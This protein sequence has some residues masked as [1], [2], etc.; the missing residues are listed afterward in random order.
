LGG[1][2]YWDN[3]TEVVFVLQTDTLNV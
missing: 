2:T 1:R 3:D